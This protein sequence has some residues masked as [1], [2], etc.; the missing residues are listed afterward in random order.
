MAVIHSLKQSIA[1]S[2]GLKIMNGLYIYS[3][4]PKDSAS[5]IG[6]FI[7]QPK[8]PILKHG[9]FHGVFRHNKPLGAN[10][11]SVY[12]PFK[13]Q[14]PLCVIY[15]GYVGEAVLSFLVIYLLSCAFSPRKQ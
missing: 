2:V 13:M 12:V 4:L 15:S 11:F 7:R 3:L 10:K 9:G 6:I 5:R 8:S 1:C 14:K